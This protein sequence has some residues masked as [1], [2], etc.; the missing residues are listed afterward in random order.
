MKIYTLTLSRGEPVIVP[1][2]LPYTEYD[3]C[4][5]I[6]MG[7]CVIL[8]DPEYFDFVEQIISDADDPEEDY[9]E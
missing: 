9:D 3:D 2:L 5:S 4:N 1:G 7:S 8:L 6:Y